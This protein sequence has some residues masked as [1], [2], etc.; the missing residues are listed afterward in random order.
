MPIIIYFLTLLAK[1]YSPMPKFIQEFERFFKKNSSSKTTKSKGAKKAE[2][3]KQR[4]TSEITQSGECETISPLCFSFSI[5]SGNSVVDVLSTER[6]PPMSDIQDSAVYDSSY[7]TGDDEV[8]SE[9]VSMQLCSQNLQVMDAPHVTF[10]PSFVPTR[11]PSTFFCET[12]LENARPRSSPTMTLDELNLAYSPTYFFSE[13]YLIVDVSDTDLSSWID[14]AFE[15]ETTQEPVNYVDFYERSEGS[16]SAGSEDG[17]VEFDPID[18]I[19]AIINNL[20]PPLSDGGLDEDFQLEMY[21]RYQNF[22]GWDFPLCEEWIQRVKTMEMP[23]I[24]SN[25]R[26]Y[27]RFRYYDLVRVKLKNNEEVDLQPLMESRVR[28][29]VTLKTR[30]L[31]SGSVLAGT[32]SFPLI[33][34]PQSILMVK[35]ALP[36]QRPGPISIE[37]LKSD[38]DTRMKMCVLQ[39]EQ[40]VLSGITLK[41]EEVKNLMDIAHEHAGEFV[42][43]ILRSF[44]GISSTGK[45]FISLINRLQ[46]LANRYMVLNDDLFRSSLNQGNPLP[47]LLETLVDDCIE[48]QEE[49]AEFQEGFNRCHA[50]MQS[51]VDGLV[52]HAN[53]CLLYLAQCQSIVHAGYPLDGDGLH[54][55]SSELVWNEQYTRNLQFLQNLKAKRI[56][57]FLVGDFDKMHTNSRNVLEV[58][59]DLLRESEASFNEVSVTH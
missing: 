27:R 29:G 59:E 57:R 19:A 55:S 15:E 47:R 10:A 28:F 34:A 39:L 1:L 24:L 9:L 25:H 7:D 23:A 5:H 35:N 21:T 14:L 18:E 17:E 56:F 20:E 13:E 36:R 43:N 40:K 22:M 11:F 58:C 53:D 31:S 12:D 4:D 44:E 38:V 50:Y 30:D 2:K 8:L 33:Q 52:S 49:I 48:L 46:A 6:P 3:S 54:G 32:S 45:R 41:K 51:H 37:F 16:N 42:E 26:E